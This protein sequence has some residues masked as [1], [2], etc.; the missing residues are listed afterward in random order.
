PYL[1]TGRILVAVSGG[2]DSVVLAHLCKSAK[3]DFA[4]AHCNFN[5]RGDESDADEEFLLDLADA[6]NV[7]IF[8]Q[9]FDTTAYSKD[10]K[11]SIQMA[12]REL[13]YNWFQ[14]LS[15]TL[16]F[17]YILTAHHANDDLETFLINFIRGTGI[18][19]LTG[20]KVE[21]DKIIRPLMRF[22]RKE[23]E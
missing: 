9:N 6:L 20:I 3:L 21:N 15:S 5:L 22:S 19:G 23:I 13:R 10:A 14:E 11:I 18:E 8:T 12:A 17:D 16:Q 7:E 1:A 2:V 4:I